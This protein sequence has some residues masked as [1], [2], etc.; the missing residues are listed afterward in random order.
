[1]LGA[2]RTRA[3]AAL[4]FI[5]A[6]PILL[7][8]I[9]LSRYDYFPAFITVLAVALLLSGRERLA[10]AVIGAGI[11]VKLYPVDPPA[12]RADR[13]VAEIRAPRHARGSRREPRRRRRRLPA[14]RRAR[15]ARC[16]AVAVAAGA[17]AARGR[18]LRGRAL[19][20]RASRR[21]PA[22]ALGAELRLEQHRDVRRASRGN[23]VRPARPR[24]P[25][26]DL[27]PV[28]ARLRRPRRDR[29]RVRGVRDGLRHLRQ[30]AVAAVH[31]LAVPARPARPRAARPL[32]DRD[33]RESRRC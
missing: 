17:A 3:Y 4:V 7:G 9:A 20:R 19:D 5:G 23:A 26:R 14:V 10:C 25:R 1:M 33:P 32:G 15:G 11:V 16:L 27:D 31:G 22:A 21:R 12:G 2:S 13:A 29:A 30:G 28:R 24:D 6:G 18:E 8:P